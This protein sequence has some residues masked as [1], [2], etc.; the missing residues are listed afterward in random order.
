VL[1]VRRAPC[2]V[3]RPGESLHALMRRLGDSA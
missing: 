3:R 1:L 2:A